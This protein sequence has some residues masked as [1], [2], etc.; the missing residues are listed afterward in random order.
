[1]VLFT[2]MVSGL[3]LSSR[4]ELAIGSPY[5][6]TSADGALLPFVIGPAPEFAIIIIFPAPP[7]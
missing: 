3:S 2:D 5:K 1:M 6:S 7:F 4:P